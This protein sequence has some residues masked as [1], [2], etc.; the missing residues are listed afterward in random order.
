MQ[1]RNPAKK[2]GNLPLRA[3]SIRQR[4]FPLRP[5]TRRGKRPIAIVKRRIGKEPKR[6]F[7]ES[8]LEQSP[9]M[10][11]ILLKLQVKE[12]RQLRL[13]SAKINNVIF[14]ALKR[15]V[16]VTDAQFEKFLHQIKEFEHLA[17]RL[18]TR[19]HE[20]FKESLHLRVDMKKAFYERRIH[21]TMHGHIGVVG[22][23]DMLFRKKIINEQQVHALLNRVAE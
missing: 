3:N 2:N 18:Y 13:L 22:F 4:A 6:A 1:S 19:D 20:I 15:N 9:E 11:R 14:E 7:K 17:G 10:R 12:S 16:P 21:D 8:F 23:A 5:I